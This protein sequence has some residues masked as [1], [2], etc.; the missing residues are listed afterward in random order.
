MG[1]AGGTAEEECFAAITANLVMQIRRL[2][3]EE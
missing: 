3:D 2:A 1:S